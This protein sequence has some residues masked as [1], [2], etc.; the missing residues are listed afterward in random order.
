MMTAQITSAQPARPRRRMAV[1]LSALAGIG[2]AAAWIISL[3]VSVSVSV[4][5][6]TKRPRV[7]AS[8]EGALQGGIFGDGIGHESAA[9]PGA[10]TGSAGQPRGVV[11]ASCAKTGGLHLQAGRP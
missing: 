2:Y 6:V 1:S 9:L 10:R 5:H 8:P 3:S 7:R 4:L 11:A